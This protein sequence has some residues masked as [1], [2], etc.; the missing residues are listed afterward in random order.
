MLP[1]LQ[2]SFEVRI[3]KFIIKHEFNNIL[4]LC[5]YIFP[6]CVLAGFRFVCLDVDSLL[7]KL[8]LKAY[9]TAVIWLLIRIFLYI[10]LNKKHVQIAS[11]RKLTC[12]NDYYTKYHVLSVLWKLG[13]VLKPFTYYV[14]AILCR[15]MSVQCKVCVVLCLC[16]IMSVKFSVCEVR[17]SCIIMSA[18]QYVCVDEYWWTLAIQERI[19]V[20][21]PSLSLNMA[22]QLL[23][24][25][26]IR[27]LSKSFRT[28][29]PL[30]QRYIFRTT[31]CVI[32]YSISM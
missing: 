5:T 17:C 25:C 12:L 14:L 8:S 24:L 26:Y 6:R 19:G 30:I 29:S 31:N 13:K 23:K 1:V 15:I 3:Y 7:I 4:T 9:F 21:L 27:F 10:L 20:V 11:C 2:F 32:K 16:I 28:N 18:I 22:E